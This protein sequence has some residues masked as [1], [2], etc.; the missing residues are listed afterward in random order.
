MFARATE[1]LSE[2]KK[3][4]VCARYAIARSIVRRGAMHVFLQLLFAVSVRVLPKWEG[5]DAAGATGSRFRFA[6]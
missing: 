1:R 3:A 6:A 5:V 2:V 4:R